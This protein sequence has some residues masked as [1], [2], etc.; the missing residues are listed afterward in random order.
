METESIAD[1]LARARA[2]RDASALTEGRD[3][4][5]RAWALATQQGSPEDRAQAGHLLCLF[6][7]RLG[8]LDALLAI[9]DAVLAALA[10]TER[11]A[12]RADL[13]RWLALA[14]CETG[15]F[16]SALRRANDACALSQ[17]LGDRRQ[18]ALSLTTLGACFERM[19]DPWQAE[20]LMDEALAIANEFGDPFARLVT[21]NNLCAACVGAYYVLRGGDE[22]AEA[23]AALRRALAHARE[24]HSLLSIFDDPFFSVFVEGN[25]GEVLLHLGNT[26]EA[27]RLLDAALQRGLEHGYEAQVWRIRCSICELMLAQGQARDAHAALVK[28]LHDMR[29]DD[30]RS[31]LIRVHHALYR[32][33]RELGWDAQALGHF[34]QHERLERR[35]ATNQLKAQ[36]QLFVTRVEAEQARQQ[37]ERARLEAQVER[38]RAA[39]FQA[40]AQR[41]Q[42]TGLGNRRHLDHR[43]PMLLELAQRQNLPLTVA[44]VDLDHFKQINDRFGHAVG[45]KVL[46][47][48]AQQLRE[49]TRATD[50]LARIGGEEFL[51]VFPDMPSAQAVEVCERLRAR[52][53]RH[54]WSALAPELRVTLSVGLA[55]APPYDLATLF[56]DADRAMYRAKNEGRNRVTVA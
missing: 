12:T 21:L 1:L 13:L 30:S 4:A 26:L 32:A 15:R 14:A 44:L 54:D 51:V 20:R 36:S 50:V 3:V 25:L 7:Y 2:A 37:A 9:G 18:F 22:P 56:D 45:D 16:D 53:E 23:T 24:A 49:N 38:S 55:H 41:D 28:L 19:G 10:A 39:S 5:A 8:A 48:M 6:H 17:E 11:S 42:L 27:R 46:I 34:E 35:R 52:V 40:D 33:C 43:L 31:T 29:D 47:A